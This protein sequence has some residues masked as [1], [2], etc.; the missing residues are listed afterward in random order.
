AH[1]GAAPSDDAAPLAETGGASDE[2]GASPPNGVGTQ[3]EPSAA[4][5][6]IAPTRPVFQAAP[7]LETLGAAAQPAA[8]LS[9]PSIGGP[10]ATPAR[11]DLPEPLTGEILA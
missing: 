11:P 2:L 9:D 8:A 4:G 3:G 6:V 10:A 5:P 7:F 1:S